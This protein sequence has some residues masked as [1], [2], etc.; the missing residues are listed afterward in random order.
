VNENMSVAV[1]VVSVPEE[2]PDAAWLM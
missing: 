2:D 1:E